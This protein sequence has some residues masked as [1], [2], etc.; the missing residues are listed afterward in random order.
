MEGISDNFQGASLWGEIPLSISYLSVLG[1]QGHFSGGSSPQGESLPWGPPA[2]RQGGGHL[3]IS[4]KK[5]QACCKTASRTVLP[6]TTHCR[7]SSS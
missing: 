2:F 3:T 5:N 1:S 7:A 6:L 4:W